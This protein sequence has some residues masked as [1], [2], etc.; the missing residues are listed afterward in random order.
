MSIY[1]WIFTSGM[2]YFIEIAYQEGWR[3]LLNV[4]KSKIIIFSVEELCH[5]NYA[6]KPRLLSIISEKIKN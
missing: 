6:I 1:K 3:W 5:K 2:G 4:H